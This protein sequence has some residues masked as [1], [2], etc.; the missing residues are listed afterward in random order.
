[1]DYIFFL[2]CQIAPDLRQHF[3]DKEQRY[4]NEDGFEG[5]DDDSDSDDN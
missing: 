4:Y 3:C 1:M 5:N 2:G